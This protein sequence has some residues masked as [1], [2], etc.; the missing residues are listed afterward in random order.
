M[1]EREAKAER[2]RKE[3]HNKNKEKAQKLLRE[4]N[5]YRALNSNRVSEDE[6][7]IQL[8]TSEVSNQN[9]GT[10]KMTKIKKNMDIKQESSVFQEAEIEPSRQRGKENAANIPKR[11]SITDKA[12]SFSR[13]IK[14]KLRK[15][16]GNKEEVEQK[17]ECDRLFLSEQQNRDDEQ[18][19]LQVGERREIGLHQKE[20]E[21]A[22][23]NENEEG[24]KQPKK[25]EEKMKSQV[26]EERQIEKEERQKKEDERERDIAKEKMKKEIDRIQSE[27]EDEDDRTG[28]LQ[29]MKEEEDDMRRQQEEERKNKKEEDVEKLKLLKKLKEDKDEKRRQEEE[30]RINKKE[31]E[32]DEDR[33][34]VLEKQL[35]KEEEDKRLHQEV[36]RLNNKDEM[37]KKTSEEKT[38]F[39]PFLYL[40]IQALVN[41][42]DSLSQQ[43]TNMDCIEVF[44]SPWINIFGWFLE[45]FI[46][47]LICFKVTESLQKKGN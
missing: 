17:T 18:R 8:K 28:R 27:K 25:E 15:V 7:I 43:A 14:N 12:V 34:A 29:R 3:E 11:K 30:G 24:R 37:K 21:V 41:P 36:G 32:D 39:I 47:C 38:T 23:K 16:R 42:L 33:V 6:K 4:T 1:A 19:R 46:N 35:I 20:N 5:L 9:K 31:N 44:S 40:S 22:K 10:V 2:L 45:E 13:W 26:E